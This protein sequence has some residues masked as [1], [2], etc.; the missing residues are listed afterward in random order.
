MTPD[1]ETLRLE[2]ERTRFFSRRPPTLGETFGRNVRYFRQ[3]RGMTQKMFAEILRR[4]GVPRATEDFV[5]DIE[6]GRSDSKLY[7]VQGIEEALQ[8]GWPNLLLPGMCFAKP[9]RIKDVL[10]TIE[11]NICLYATNSKSTMADVLRN[12]RIPTPITDCTL[13]GL[14]RLQVGL[15][16]TIADLLD[17][18][19]S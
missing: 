1:L 7:V 17:S 9:R 8:C 3:Q 15:G 19:E 5:S 10:N 13:Q 4:H 2:E 14:V 6:N 18:E 16:C 11:T 12:A